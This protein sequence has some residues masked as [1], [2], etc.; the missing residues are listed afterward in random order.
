MKKYVKAQCPRCNTTIYYGRPQTTKNNC[1]N[2][3]NETHQKI[4]LTPM[5]A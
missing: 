3:F 2:C 1:T 4:T 5:A